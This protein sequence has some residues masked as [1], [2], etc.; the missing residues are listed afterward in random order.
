MSTGNGR[1]Q[2]SARNV[3]SRRVPERVESKQVPERWNSGPVSEMWDPSEY[4]R[5]A[6]VSNER[7]TGEG[8]ESGRVSENHQ[9][10]RG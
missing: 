3:E 10:K 5:R 1:I 2:A 4:R 7:R 9:T 6:W 8:V